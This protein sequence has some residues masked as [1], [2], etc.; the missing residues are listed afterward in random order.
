[1]NVLIGLSW[2]EP[3]ITLY[4]EYAAG[5]VNNHIPVWPLDLQK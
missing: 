1:M 2:Q 4:L 5:S 3:V